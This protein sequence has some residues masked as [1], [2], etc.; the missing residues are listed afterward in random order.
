VTW[1]PDAATRD[2][3]AAPARRTRPTAPSSAGNSRTTSLFGGDPALVVPVCER[4]LPGRVD[5]ATLDQINAQA[6]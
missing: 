5:P 4:P 6:E 2:P 1:P 3:D